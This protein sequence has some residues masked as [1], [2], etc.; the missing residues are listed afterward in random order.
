MPIPKIAM[1]TIMNEEKE[2]SPPPLFML[3]WFSVTRCAKLAVYDNHTETRIWPEQLPYYKDS[4]YRLEVRDVES[5]KCLGLLLSEPENVF[6]P[7]KESGLEAGILWLRSPDLYPVYLREGLGA[8]CGFELPDAPSRGVAHHKTSDGGHLVAI[9]I[10]KTEAWAHQPEEPIT[11]RFWWVNAHDAF[12]GYW[13][14]KKRNYVRLGSAPAEAVLT[15]SIAPNVESI[16]DYDRN[17]PLD[18]LRTYNFK[19]LRTRRNLR[20]SP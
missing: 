20:L 18:T 12:H 2:G 6:V 15:A 19:P 8:C 14:C 7:A 11:Y 3:D 13:P 5:G 16:Q 10:I 17:F 9:T 4:R 1:Q